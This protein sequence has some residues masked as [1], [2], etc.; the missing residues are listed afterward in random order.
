MY[1]I[2]TFI[3]LDIFVVLYVV[4]YSLINFFISIIFSFIID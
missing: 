3:N 2:T 1:F 4:A